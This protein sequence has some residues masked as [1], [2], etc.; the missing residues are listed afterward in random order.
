MRSL[1]SQGGASRST[2]SCTTSTI[3]GTCS[4]RKSTKMPSNRSAR[5]V[6]YLWTAHTTH[7][8]TL[9]SPNLAM[10]GDHAC[11]MLAHLPSV[12]LERRHACPCHLQA[13]PSEHGHE[14][15]GRRQRSLRD[16]DTQVG[17]KALCCF[18]ADVGSKHGDTNAILRGV[19][20]CVCTRSGECRCTKTSY[21]ELCCCVCYLCF[22]IEP[23]TLFPCCR[24]CP[25]GS[26]VALHGS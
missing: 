22:H 24:S 20:V 1:D 9:A 26:R 2:K 4:L 16:R 23:C 25:Q 6:W 17:D 14:R 19:C 3:M 7:T 11:L 8:P 18:R 12:E 5:S 21:A 15:D 10:V 13:I